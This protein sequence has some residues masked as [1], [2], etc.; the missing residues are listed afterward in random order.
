MKKIFRYS[1]AALAG[2]LLASCAGD[3]DDWA[4]P[5][6]N[7]PEEVAAKYGVSFA[8][9]P[10]ANIAMPV[11]NDD[12]RLVAISASSDKVA[13]FALTNLTIN[14]E[15]INATIDNGF[16]IVSAEELNNLSQNMFNSRANTARQL[17]IESQVSI[18]LNN[19]DAV[20]T[21]VI[22]NTTATFTPKA[23]PAIDSKGYFLLGNF[24]EN[25]AGW[26]LGAPVWMTNNGDGTYTA[27][28]TTTSDE[29]NWYKFYAGS[30]Y[31]ESSW[32]EVNSGQMGC[33]VNG[34]NARSGFI[35]YTGDDQPVQTPVIS[36]K[37]MFEVTIDMVNLTY[38]VK[39]LAVNLYIVGGPNDWT[40]SAAS[41]E[42]KF[43][44]PNPDVA[45][46]TITFPG[47]EDGSCWFAI[48][49]DKGC[50][51]ITNENN[52]KELYGTTSG[53]GNQ[54]ESGTLTR[55][56]NLGD[57]GSFCVDN[58]KYITVTVNLDDMSYTVK[59]T[60]F[61]SYIYEAGVNN[62]WGSVEQ[63]LF[64]ANG[65]GIYTGY[66]YAQDADW[67]G[68]K[69]A[70]KFRGNAGDWDN[71]NY[72]PG[73]QNDDLT[74]TLIDSGDAGNIFVEPGFYRADVDLATMT[75]KL[76]A[77]NSVYV[78]GSAVNNDWDNGVKMTYNLTK[79]CWEC[80]AT[81]TEAG[82]IK[83][84]G[85]GTWDNE[86]GNWGGSLDNII[87]GTNDNIPVSLTGDV[88]IEFYPICDNKS[89]ATVTAR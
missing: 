49:D 76:T 73:T 64:C 59:A 1:F 46:Y 61:A 63:P 31:S 67:S 37:G 84:K 70:F 8:A 25:G 35:V 71:G 24:E 9:G 87:N 53:N 22:G 50:D 11:S 23:T 4:N 81:F 33:A 38:H 62:D 20:T 57:D 52:W 16:I 85:N 13:N 19:G 2:I 58:A 89:Y 68:G 14:G 27:V 44:Q 30:N 36:G 21:D 18:I 7:D 41:K 56:S 82:V 40:A 51:A 3:Y 28:V 6:S 72:G 47:V 39:Q 45:F 78:V 54:G 77:I 69:G 83:F 80:D 65:D 10:D 12:V 74:G 17:Q 79:R 86:D 55:R 60:N 29:D 15:E 66:F 5:Q 43:T 32:D 88:H 75:F 34:D 26:D 48:G 42:L